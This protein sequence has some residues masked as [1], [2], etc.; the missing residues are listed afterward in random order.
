MEVE[1][2]R[3]KKAHGQHELSIK[4]GGEIKMKIT[5]DQVGQV[6]SVT[7]G[8]GNPCERASLTLNGQNVID[9]DPDEVVIHAHSSPGCTYYWYRGQ[10]WQK[11]S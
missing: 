4:I 3:T 2:N 8:T 6:I 7:D 10:V 1:L 11:C 9:M 5:K